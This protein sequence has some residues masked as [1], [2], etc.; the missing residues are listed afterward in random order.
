MV[1]VMNVKYMAGKLIVFY[2]INNLGKSTQA[3]LLVERLKRS[4]HKAEYFKYPL[5]DLEPTG[6]MLNAYLRQGNPLGLTPR[7][8]QLVYALNRSQ[9]QGELLAKLE[10]GIYVVAEDYF[11]TGIAW[12]LA[13]GIDEHFLRQINADFYKPDVAFLFDG[14]RFVNSIETGHTH[15]SDDELTARCRQIHHQLG[16]EESWIDIDANGQIEEIR[17]IIW[18]KLAAKL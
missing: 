4:G 9:Y 10:A 16:K 7:E 1:A 14:E 5:Y 18:D 12:G 2:G 6:P 11:H 13:R 17:E 3:A 8:A 15:E